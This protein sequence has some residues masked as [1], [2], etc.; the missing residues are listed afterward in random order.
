MTYMDKNFFIISWNHHNIPL[1]Y[2]ELLSLNKNDIKRFIKLSLQHASILEIAVLS[3]CNRI[4]FHIISKD[5][6]ES[7]D[8]MKIIHKIIIRGKFDWKNNNP[9]I[10]ANLDAF[11]HLCLV[12]AGFGSKVFGESQITSQVKNAHRILIDNQP[13]ARMLDYFYKNALIC[14]K[15]IRYNFFNEMDSVSVSGLI[16]QKI[17]DMGNDFHNFSILILGAGESATLTANLF[18]KH[19]VSKI[20]IVNRNVKNGMSLSKDISGVFFKMD[21]MEEA[22]SECDVIVAA[23]NSNEYLVHKSQIKNIMKTRRETLLLFDISSPRNI[24]PS[25][26][27]IENVFLFDLDTLHIDNAYQSKEK[28]NMIDNALQLIDRYPIELHDD[29]ESD[30]PEA[31]LLQLE[32]AFV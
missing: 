1:K 20:Y 4:E 25:T 10:F 29:L 3:T 6:D 17:K 27:D 12:S 11:K 24:D 18:K 21:D 5:I 2:R 22:L 15:K 26:C 23:T 32:E 13:N 7:M 8:A 31:D 30:E 28:Q 9:E 16:I 19:G 14:S